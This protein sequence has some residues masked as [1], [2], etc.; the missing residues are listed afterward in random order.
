MS[1]SG[2]FVFLA[3]MRSFDPPAWV[4]AT[5]PTIATTR[6]TPDDPVVRYLTR[7]AAARAFQP[8]FGADWEQMILLEPVPA[9]ADEE[10]AKAV[11]IPPPPPAADI[12]AALP[13]NPPPPPV[14]TVTLPRHTLEQVTQ[15]LDQ[16]PRLDFGD[17]AI[18][19]WL[20]ATKLYLAGLCG[21]PVV[22]PYPGQAPRQ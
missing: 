13:P 1:G 20:G 3:R 8:F 15:F 7:D 18:L 19:N 14:E 9:T 10:L 17:P 22:M 4:T 6:D 5:D 12:P 11:L 16:A 21:L 2:V